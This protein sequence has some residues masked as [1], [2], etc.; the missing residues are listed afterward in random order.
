M[1]AIAG[2]M[3]TLQNNLKAE[4]EK[5]KAL[6]QKLA[7]CTQMLD[8]LKLESKKA[9]VDLIS[10]L[11][12]FKEKE[13]GSDKNYK[14][15]IIDLK[16]MNQRLEEKLTET[17]KLKIAC[18]HELT[19]EREKTESL[20]HRMKALESETQSVWR[21]IKKRHRKLRKYGITLTL[22]TIRSR[23]LWQKKTNG[24]IY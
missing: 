8:A 1:I 17:L 12:A 16:Y 21:E 13:M 19:K 4:R 10:A 7:T 6:Q 24:T 14:A 5:N 23:D 15:E 2:A 11:A 9:H 3:R 18:E 20:M 22:S